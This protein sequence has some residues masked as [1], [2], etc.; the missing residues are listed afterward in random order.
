VET[1]GPLAGLNP[2]FIDGVVSPSWLPAHSAS[3]IGWF[4]T[5]WDTDRRQPDNQS[6][7]YNQANLTRGKKRIGRKKRGPI[8][9]GYGDLCGTL[10][11]TI[12]RC[13]SG[14]LAAVTFF[15]TN[16]GR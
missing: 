13:G 6:G 11:A 9:F 3:G 8:L 2:D 10:L 1:P 12:K 4:P 15:E 7:K 16:K 5:I 14:V